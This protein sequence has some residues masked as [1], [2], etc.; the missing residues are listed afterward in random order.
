MT[1]ETLEAKTTHTEKSTSAQQEKEVVAL[2]LAGKSA[3]LPGNRPVEAKHL[4]IVN[5]YASVGGT[6]PVVKSGLDIKGT[7]TVSGSRPIT[8]SHLHISETYKVMGNRPVASNQIDDPLML[9][10]YLD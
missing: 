9:M 5:T 10:G 3:L 8:A 2:K 4:Q 1:T 7:M 6:R